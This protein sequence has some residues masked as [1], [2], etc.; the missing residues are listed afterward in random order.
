MNPP[1]GLIDEIR[2]LIADLV[3]KRY[4]AIDNDGRGGRLSAG[5]LEG[6]IEEYGGTLVDLPDDAASLIDAIPTAG[7][8]D[9]LSVDVPLWTTE[10]GR[11]DLTLSL[12]ATRTGAA[13][14]LVIE[15][16]HVL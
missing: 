7:S 16:L 12:T 3:A 11:S 6:T 14:S 10:E 9:S 8:H 5:G 15:D 13:W 4:L 1:P 2:R